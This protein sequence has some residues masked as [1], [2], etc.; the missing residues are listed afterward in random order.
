MLSLN[1]QYLNIKTCQQFYLTILTTNQ[2]QILT[3][4]LNHIHS[5]LSK[6]KKSPHDIDMDETELNFGKEMLEICSLD[7]MKEIFFYLLADKRFSVQKM[8][9]LILIEIHE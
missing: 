3:I 4:V 6:I 1:L 9:L 8:I 2:Y 7:D 5:I